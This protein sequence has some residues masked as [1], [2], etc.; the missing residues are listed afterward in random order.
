MGLRKYSHPPSMLKIEFKRILRAFIPST[1]PQSQPATINPLHL[2]AALKAEKRTGRTTETDPAVP[3]EEYVY[4]EG[5]YILV[6]DK[7][8]V[9]KPIMVREYPVGSTRAE[10]LWPMFWSCTEGHCPFI[11]PRPEHKPAADAKHYA[12][13]NLKAG[14]PNPIALQENVQIQNRKD[15]PASGII[16]SSNQF[17]AIRSTTTCG[18]TSALSGLGGAIHV[19]G[20]LSREVR[21]LKNRLTPATIM[22]PPAKKRRTD[23]LR[24]QLAAKTKPKEK[25]EGYCENCKDHYDDY[26]EV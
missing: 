2:S 8:Q 13:P 19:K 23:T 26:Q 16:N 14:T 22:P 5:P 4:F 17:S 9:H 24:E 3:R 15:Q 20:S 1:P 6:S 10:A 21:D 25:R 7:A 11:R 12:R 18:V